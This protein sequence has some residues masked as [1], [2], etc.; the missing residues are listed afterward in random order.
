M[1]S[2]DIYKFIYTCRNTFIL[3]KFII[4][5]HPYVSVDCRRHITQGTYL[6]WPEMKYSPNAGLPPAATPAPSLPL[7]APTSPTLRSVFYPVF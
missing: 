6:F 1:Y 2:I 4:K 3:V 5:I 7:W